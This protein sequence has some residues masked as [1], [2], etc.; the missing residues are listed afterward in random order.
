MGG[1]PEQ[2]VADGKDTI[3][4]NLEDKNEMP[5]ESALRQR[6]PILL[7]GRLALKIFISRSARR[8]QLGFVAS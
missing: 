1:A 2:A 8:S 5:A 6:Q 3:F 4:D 7:S